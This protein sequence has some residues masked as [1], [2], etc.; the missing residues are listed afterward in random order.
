MGE[1]SPEFL[2]RLTDMVPELVEGGSEAFEP[3][4]FEEPPLP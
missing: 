4:D 1:M 3:E 2:E